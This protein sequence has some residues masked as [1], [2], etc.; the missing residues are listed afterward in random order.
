MTMAGHTTLA[1]A[2]KKEAPY[3][4]EKISPIGKITPTKEPKNLNNNNFLSI[5]HP[6]KKL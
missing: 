3:A 2:P 1:K 4:K 6:K 5:K